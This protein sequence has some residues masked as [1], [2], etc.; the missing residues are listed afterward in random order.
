MQAAHPSVMPIDPWL[1]M[2]FGGGFVSGGCQL[3]GDGTCNGD[4]NA[5]HVH[6][7]WTFF[8]L[9]AVEYVFYVWV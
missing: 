1:A 7:I 6:P 4:H 8:H 3:I 5:F 2:Q 9:H